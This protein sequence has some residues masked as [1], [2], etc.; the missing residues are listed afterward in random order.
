[1]TLAGNADGTHEATINEKTSNGR[2]DFRE[3]MEVEKKSSPMVG[4]IQVEVAKA[5]EVFRMDSP[6]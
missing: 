6:Q 4:T 3:V 5:L 1:M 2:T